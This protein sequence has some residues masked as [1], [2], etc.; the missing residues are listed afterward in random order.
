MLPW[1]NHTEYDE[2]NKTQEFT[3]SVNNYYS[4]TGDMF[5][6]DGTLDEN[7]REYITVEYYENGATIPAKIKTLYINKQWEE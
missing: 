7:N 1:T 5:F 3:S 6:F 2:I 4:A